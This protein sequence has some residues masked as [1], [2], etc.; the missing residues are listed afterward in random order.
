MKV[1]VAGASGVVGRRLVPSLVEA[2]HEVVALSTTAEGA[3]ALERTEVRGVVGDV[4]DHGRMRELL[5][6]ERPDAVMFEIS[7][8]PRSLGPGA[9]KSQFAY[10]VL[11]RTVGVRNV[12]D[13]ARAA[14]TRRIVAQSYAHIY[15][16]QGSWVKEESESLNLGEHVPEDRRR[17]VEAVVSLEGAV[18]DTPG[19]EGVALRYGSLYGPRTAYDWSGSVAELVRARHYPLVGGGTGWTSFVHVDDAAHAAVLALDGPP[20]RFNIVDDEPAPV[21]VWLPEYAKELCAPV[22]RR[23]PAAVVRALSRERFAFRSTQQ[24][25]AD[26]RWARAQMGFAPRFRSWREGFRAEFELELERAA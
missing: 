20:G 13:A 8:V 22:P 21:S 26:N 23:V 10:S 3:N 11:V 9:T 7:G 6:A 17:N 5:A 14:G 12:L 15:A 24:R 4:L 16:P 18:C 2:G 19:I 25:A 1:F